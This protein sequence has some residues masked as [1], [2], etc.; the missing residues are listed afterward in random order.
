MAA[1]DSKRVMITAPHD[2][3]EF[4]EERARYHGATISAEAVMSIRQRMERERAPPGSA[5][6]RA[7]VTDVLPP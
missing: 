5:P 4:L 3:H 7:G 1:A 6:A 2:V